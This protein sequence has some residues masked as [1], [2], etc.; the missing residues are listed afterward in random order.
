MGR[1]LGP[2][3]TRQAFPEPP[4]YVNGVGAPRGQSGTVDELTSP[5]VWQCVLMVANAVASMPL[6]TFRFTPDLPVKVPSPDVVARPSV[7]STQSEWMHT[8]MV[9]LLLRGNGYARILGRDIAARPTGMQILNP[10]RVLPLVDAD[11]QR[12]YKIGNTIVP[13]DDIF[14]VRGMTFPGSIAGLSPISYAA[15]TIGLDIS[16]RDFAK[17]FLEGSGIP[18]AILTSPGLVDQDKAKAIKARFLDASRNREPA[19]MS[20]QVTYTPIQIKPEESQ[21]LATQQMSIAHIARFFGIPPRKVGGTDGSSLTYANLQQENMDFLQEGVNP[22]LVRVQDA[23]SLLLPPPEFVKFDTTSLTRMDPM[24]EVER[25]LILIAAKIKAPSESRTFLGYS[26]ATPEQIA[27]MELVPLT[28]TPTGK[29][30]SIPGH[31]SE[32]AVPPIPPV[33][34][35]AP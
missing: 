9:S 5:A 1:F 3:Q 19:V 4:I 13:G 10:D 11:G 24:A 17:D 25:E 26:P 35:P 6:E 7:D 8:F 32:P 23:F 14:H 20:D 30:K 21:F 15:M 16:S 22:W 2:R 12:A 29:A 28:I 34:V 33:P 27:E 18:K 31:P